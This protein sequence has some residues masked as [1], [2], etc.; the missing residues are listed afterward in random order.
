MPRRYDDYQINVVW[1]GFGGD[2]AAIHKNA[3]HQTGSAG[4][5]KEA[6]KSGE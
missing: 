5:G 1:I 2:K 6:F 3:A 4:F